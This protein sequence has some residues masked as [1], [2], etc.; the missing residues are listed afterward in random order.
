MIA[1]FA[2]KKGLSQKAYFDAGDVHF[3][4]R[5][6]SEK[7]RV[8]AL[9]QV[10]ALVLN[11]RDWKAFGRP[12][13]ET[14]WPQEQ[15]FQSRSTTSLLIRL[16]EQI[17]TR[18]ADIVNTVQDWLQP[19]S[20]SSLHDFTFEHPDFERKTVSLCRRYPTQ[21]LQILERVVGGADDASPYEL[22][23]ALDQIAVAE[24]SLVSTRAWRRLSR[25]AG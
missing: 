24:P 19:G 20:I 22:R 8:A 2:G 13:F 21:V 10:Q 11:S 17:P 16:A 7:G 15:V 3:I 6:L 4:L 18:Y 1:V 23:E 14:M 12:F 25:M 5:Q 9:E